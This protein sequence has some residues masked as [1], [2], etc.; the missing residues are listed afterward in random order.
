MR[1][2]GGGKIRLKVSW[3]AALRAVRAW[4]DPWIMLWRYWRGWSD[5]PPP[6]QL[7]EL[8]EWLRQ[9]RGI[10]VYTTF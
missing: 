4:L 5:K 1:W 8:L 2:R 9:G 7:Q 3:P 6:S 10:D